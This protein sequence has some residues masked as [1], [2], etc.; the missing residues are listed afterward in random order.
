VIARRDVL[1]AVDA[2]FP[3]E[4]IAISG[5][6]WGLAWLAA[7]IGLW[8]HK[9]Q[10]RRAMLVLPPLYV[11]ASLGEQLW[12]VRGDYERGQLP[13]QITVSVLLVGIVLWGLT[14]TGIRLAFQHGQRHEEPE[15]Q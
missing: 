15:Q 2:T 13:F 8:L 3:F 1:S 12:L 4:M 7:G 11:I 14:R 5:L 9:E 6:V 10:A